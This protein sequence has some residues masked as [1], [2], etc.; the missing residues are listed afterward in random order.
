MSYS[1]EIDKNVT[2]EVIGTEYDSTFVI[3]QEK[4]IDSEDNL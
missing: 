2:N 1:P 3:N 4:D